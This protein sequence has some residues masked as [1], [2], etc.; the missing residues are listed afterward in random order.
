MQ[1][2]YFALALFLVVT[3]SNTSVFAQ[4]HSLSEQA[5][6][7]LIT[8]LPGEAPEEYF[9]HSAIRVYDPLNDRDFSFNYG[10]FH[11]DSWFMLKFIYGDLNYFLS[12]A[13]F[14]RSLEHYR[15]RRRPVI[16]QVLNLTFDQKQELYD[17][18]LNNAREENRYYQYDFLFDNCSTRIRDAIQTVFGQDIQFADKPD[19][20]LTFRELIALYVH[21]KPFDRFGIDVLLGSQ[22]DRVAEPWETMFLPDYLMEV[23]DHASIT[24][25]GRDEPL[26]ANTELILTIDD[27][28]QGN[29][30]PW[31]SLFTWILF[32]A[33][34]LVTWKGYQADVTIQRWF[35]VPL[36]AVTGLIGLLISFLWF[37]SLHVVTASNLNLFWALPTHLLAVPILIKHSNPGKRMTI[38]FLATAI[39]S[40]IL[41]AGWIF[42]PQYLPPAVF[43]LILLLLLRSSW[44]T[45]NSVLAENKFITA[46]L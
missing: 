31:V 44:I 43:P 12:I 7:S 25:D 24:I 19:P 26:V 9:G 39:V 33:G 21:H 28:D 8:I 41:L 16:E 30:F 14:P 46:D 34:L 15:Q 23:F 4:Q 2:Y 3:V 37:I 20:G 18:L 40:F 1:R 6:V 36:F 42:W 38:Y 17:F 35:D 11:F 10:T 27:Y 5:Q 29:S 22:I 45:Y 13:S 32:L